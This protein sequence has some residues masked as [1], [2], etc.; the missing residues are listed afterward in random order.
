MILSYMYCIHIIQHT[1]TWILKYTYTMTHRHSLFSTISYVGFFFSF[2][3]ITLVY[4][5]ES[6]Y[7][8]ELFIDFSMCVC[9]CTWMYVCTLCAVTKIVTVLPPTTITTPHHN[10][11]TVSNYSSTF[12][13][14]LVMHYFGRNFRT[15]ILNVYFFCV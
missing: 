14:F 11:A 7:L 1:H 15:K 10:I 6:V 5:D 3:F 4:D 13:L 8:D 2:F 12:T 9:V